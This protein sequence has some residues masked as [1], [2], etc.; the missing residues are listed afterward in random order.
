MKKELA[1]KYNHKDVE[2][3]KSILFELS[4]N[5]VLYNTL[6]S[7][8]KVHRKEAELSLYNDKLKRILRSLT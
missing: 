5:E 7:N 8:C 4:S 3:L 6:S 2:E 1:Q